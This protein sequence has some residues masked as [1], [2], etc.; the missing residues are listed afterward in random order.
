MKPTAMMRWSLAPA[1]LALAAT[2]MLSPA[3]PSEDLEMSLIEQV[4]ENEIPHLIIDGI[5]EI[6][7]DVMG[8]L[9]RMLIG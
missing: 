8:F 3:Q 4:G 9:K 7:S 1:A 6:G 5:V 2:V